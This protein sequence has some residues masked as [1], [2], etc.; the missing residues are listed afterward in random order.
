M[1]EVVGIGAA[2]FDMLMTADRFPAED[3]KL[4]GTG[5]KL[6]CGGPCA[7]ALVA[8]SKL[9]IGAE[10]IGTMGD[11]LY[12]T[13]M[14]AEFRR[15]G[16]K[17]DGVRVVPGAES[18]HSFVLLNT[19]KS[20][21]TCIWCRGSVPAPTPED[22]GLN[23]LKNA[24]VLHLDGH[25][26]ETAIYA[27]E[28]AREYGVTVSLDA[29]GTYPG[30]ERLLPLVDVL[31]SSEEFI[32]EFTGC[33]DAETAA[34]ALQ[35]RYRPKA[36]IVTQGSYGG[37][38][39]AVG[40]LVRYPVFPVDVIDTNGAGD[41]FHGAFITAQVKGMDVME[42]AAFASAASALKCTKFGAQEGIPGFDEVVRFMHN[43]KSVIL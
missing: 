26:L 18:F 29:G 11:D 28:K 39:V 38:V 32:L 1:T 6:Q 41:T 23:T 17:I 12:G 7:T 13:Y 19:A 33:A 40:G 3:T 14:L 8:V 16:V 21:R 24:K 37:F 35:S 9:G 4:E 15:F 2:L 27:A 43:A 42:S 5:T 31:I 25:Q 36:L 22:I 34:M 10:Y 20:T 30:I